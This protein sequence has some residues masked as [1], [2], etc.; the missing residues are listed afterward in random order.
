MKPRRFWTA[1]ACVLAAVTIR[2]TS[3][4]VKV[5]AH[6]SVKASSISTADLRDVFLE[7]KTSLGGVPVT[8][9]L[10]RRGVTHEV[11]V[12]EYLGKSDA[13]LASY[14]RSLVFTGK[15]SMPRS[16]DSDADVAAYV[17]KTKGAIGYVS[18]SASAPGT[19][20]LDIE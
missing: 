6:P 9:V 14:F 20:T 3:T 17:A 4:D 1:A 7:R 8:P 12:T 5:I 16:L 2:A 11:F 18:V 10:A 13:A 19:K 15:A